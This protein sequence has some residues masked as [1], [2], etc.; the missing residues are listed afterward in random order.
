MEYQEYQDAAI[1]AA[2]RLESLEW[3]VSQLRDTLAQ[4]RD[5]AD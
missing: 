1:E 3:V 4:I 2:N 5:L